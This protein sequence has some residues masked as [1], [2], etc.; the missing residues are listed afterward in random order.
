LEL[1]FSKEV[2][3]VLVLSLKLLIGTLNCGLLLVEF[4]DLLLKDVNL[5]LLLL[6]ASD[7]TLPVLESLTGL[8]VLIWIFLIGEDSCLILNLL[9]NILLLLLG[10]GA[11]GSTTSAVGIGVVQRICGIILVF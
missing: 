7:G 6:A 1:L 10:K 5:L 2:F 8:L 11:L 9:L 3:P 4:S